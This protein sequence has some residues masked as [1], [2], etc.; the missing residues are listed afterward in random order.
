MSR[1]KN[2]IP[3]LVLERIY[4]MYR[5]GYTYTTIAN[6]TKLSKDIVINRCQQA[7]IERNPIVLRNPKKTSPYDYLFDEPTAQGKMYRDYLK[8]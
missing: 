7:K 3:P 4:S 2:E 5:Q 1:K 6:V 8:K